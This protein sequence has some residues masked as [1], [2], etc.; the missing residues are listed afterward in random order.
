[1]RKRPLAEQ[2]ASY[3]RALG[4]AIRDSRRGRLSLES[5][6]ERAGVSVGQLSQVENGT[7]NPSVEVLMRIAQALG[8]EL[9]DL[10]ELPPAGHTYVVRVGDRRRYRSPVVPHEVTLL[11]PGIRHQL[12]FSYCAMRPGVVSAAEQGL[13]G[14]V[15]YYVVAGELEVRKGAASYQLGPRDSL[16]LALPHGLA[17]VSDASADYFAVFRPEDDR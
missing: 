6:A 11:T 8:L 9:S 17:N 4:A 2:D 7:G 15:L 12:S 10:V 13:H 16:L 5:L 1:M 3:L 14:D